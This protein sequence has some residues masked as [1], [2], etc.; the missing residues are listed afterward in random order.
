[1]EQLQK[2][3]KEANAKVSSATREPLLQAKPPRPLPTSSQKTPE[4]T[5]SPSLQPS[6]SSSDHRPVSA[7]SEEDI[8]I[9]ENGEVSSEDELDRDDAFGKTGSSPVAPCP[10]ID[11]VPLSLDSKAVGKAKA[12]K[13]AES[14]KKVEPGDEA[15]EAKAEAKDGDVGV[16][17]EEVTPL[18]AEGKVDREREEE[19]KG[20]TV[21][22]EKK[23]EEETE[24]EDSA[25]GKG[26]RKLSEG[27]KFD[28]GMC[29]APPNNLF[30]WLGL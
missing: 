20:E 25:K 29:R 18:P 10:Y 8:K 2:D 15:V 26:N 19:V 3:L 24:K 21:Q 11:F 22:E 12:L 4:R 17:S 9:H 23:K 28:V 7:L 13:E 1:M 5:P 6:S 16:A 14:S 27:S 30:L